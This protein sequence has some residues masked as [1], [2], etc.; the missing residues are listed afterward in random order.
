MNK[1]KI[2]QLK[3]LLCICL[4]FPMTVFAQPQSAP[5]DTVWQVYNFDYYTQHLD[6]E[7][8]T[9]GVLYNRVAPIA[10]LNYPYSNLFE[11]EEEHRGFGY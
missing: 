1:I 8:I 2:K 6:K 5:E 7:E 9:T 10:N 3:K 11:T 4:S